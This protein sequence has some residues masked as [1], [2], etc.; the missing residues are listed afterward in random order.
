MP[1]ESEK[2]DPLL[3]EIESLKLWALQEDF[4]PEDLGLQTN[5]DITV[6]RLGQIRDW[7][8]ACKYADGLIDQWREKAPTSIELLRSMKAI[9]KLLA[10]KLLMPHGKNG[11]PGEYRRMPAY[12]WT[13]TCQQ[14]RVFLTLLS[15]DNLSQRYLRSAPVLQAFAQLE[16]T[17]SIPATYLNDFFDIVIH[18]EDRMSV[19]SLERMESLYGIEPRRLLT[20]PLKEQRLIKLSYLYNNELTDEEK[21]QTTDY[22]TTEEKKKLTN[23]V[24]MPAAPKKIPAKLLAAIKEI[25]DDFKA[26]QRGDDKEIAHF[27]ANTMYKVMS[28]LPFSNGN[29]RTAV[30]LVNIFAILLNKP[31]FSFN[32]SG[33]P[34][35][36]YDNA[37]LK[38]SEEP[39][40]LDVLILER[41]ES[42]AQLFP[43]DEDSVRE[44]ASKQVMLLLQIR[45]A[46]L[47]EKLQTKS[48]NLD[49]LFPD[50]PSTRVLDTIA[51]NQCNKYNVAF[52]RSEIDYDEFL[53]VAYFIHIATCMLDKMQTTGIF[54]APLVKR[55]IDIPKKEL[56]VAAQK[57]L[58]ELTRCYTD[59]TSKYEPDSKCMIIEILE[60]AQEALI[61]GDA[62]QSEK[63]QKQTTNMYKK[64]ASTL[65]ENLH[66]IGIERA[67][68][69]CPNPD[70]LKPHFYVICSSLTE[71][72]AAKI[73]PQDSIYRSVIM[74]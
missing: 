12:T 71:I 7:Y 37:F 68:V 36:P 35:H 17:Y 43:L 48:V 67:E 70:E 55:T 57:K 39:E 13:Y 31:S 30:C 3:E 44:K 23:I 56:I 53:R 64:R 27:L 26:C 38:F 61:A 58:D 21:Q 51:S 6:N 42:A 33:Q 29:K 34:I 15:S 25:L 47:L 18:A 54:Y 19:K 63:R 16:K 59:Q 22:L 60:E 73:E 32:F 14:D 72:I 2:R 1:S 20:L 66:L 11:F 74:I 8:K 10:N 24:F 46:E 65:V 50:L 40:L 5:L 69:Y 41:I 4:V 45:A 28:I 49:R 9:H 52:P 62:E